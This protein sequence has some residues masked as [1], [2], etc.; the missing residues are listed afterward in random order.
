MSKETIMHLPLPGLQCAH[1]WKSCMHL[2]I[3][4]ALVYPARPFVDFVRICG[5]CAQLWISR[6]HLW[7]A[8]WILCMHLWIVCTSV[9]L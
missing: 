8:L 2:W 9:D 4:C 6:V 5:L 7:I 1:M 3:V